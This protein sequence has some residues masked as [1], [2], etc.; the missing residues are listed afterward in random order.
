MKTS[1]IVKTHFSRSLSNKMLLQGQSDLKSVNQQSL[2]NSRDSSLDSS[3]IKKQPNLNLT[4]FAS[5]FIRAK[6]SHHPLKISNS[7]HP[8][9]SA[10]ENIETCQDI[11]TIQEIVSKFTLKSIETMKQDYNNYEVIY[12]QFL[13]IMSEIDEIFDKNTLLQ[14]SFSRAREVF[15]LY[16]SRPGQVLLTLKSLPKTLGTIKL[17][18]KILSQSGLALKCIDKWKVKGI[19]KDVFELVSAIVNEKK[20][21]FKGKVFLHRQN[22]HGRLRTYEN[23]I[24]DEKT[25]D[26]SIM[27]LNTVP[28][29]SEYRSTSPVQTLGSE[30][31]S[32]FS[33]RC[34]FKKNKNTVKSKLIEQLYLKLNALPDQHDFEQPF[35]LATFGNRDQEEVEQEVTEKIK[36]KKSNGSTPG[37]MRALRRDESGK[38]VNVNNKENKEISQREEWEERRKVNNK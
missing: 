22:N 17:S 15:K 27:D 31:S 14:F 33:H 35:R 9:L 11:L 23:L 1:K 2:S 28:N 4:N 32:E 5:S 6:P 16:L 29:E 8:G 26:I 38:R 18:Q 12:T 37:Y 13:G 34:L 25:F 7:Q 24:T 20:S 10:S 19:A 36:K 30:E 3:K 21:N